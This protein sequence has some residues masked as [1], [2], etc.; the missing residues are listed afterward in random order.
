MIKGNKK[1]INNLRFARLRADN[2]VLK[3]SADHPANGQASAR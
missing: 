1:G 2:S 3:E